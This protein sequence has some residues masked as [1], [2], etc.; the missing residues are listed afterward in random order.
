MKKHIITST[1]VSRVNMISDTKNEILVSQKEASQA[2][3]Q[4]NM[5]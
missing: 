5:E 3:Q 2:I 1:A 4:I